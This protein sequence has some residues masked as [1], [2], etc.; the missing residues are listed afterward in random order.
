MM[1]PVRLLLDGFGCYREPAEADFSDVEFFALTGPTGAG[2]STVIDGLCF[3]LYG[4]V[5]RWGNVNVINQALAPTQTECRVALV[6]EAAGQRYGIERRL[7]R[8]PRGQ[9]TTRL[10]MIHRLDPSVPAGAPLADLLAASAEALAEG[11][12]Q[13][14]SHVQQILGLTYE[15]FTQSVLLPQGR[16]AEF[17]QA[18]PRKRQDLLVELLAFGVYEQVAK[19]AR[20]RADLAADRRKTAES[21][22]AELAGATQEAE[23]AAHVRLIELDELGITVTDRLASLDLLRAQGERAAQQASDARQETAMLAAVQ[24]PADVPDLAGRIASAVGALA[25]RKARAESAGLAEMAAHQTR[26]GLGDKAALQLALAAYGHRSDLSERLGLAERDLAAKQADERVKAAQLLAADEAFQQA[27]E[28]LAGTE[29]SNMAAALA[30]GLHVGDDC[31]VCLRALTEPPRHAGVASLTEARS[32]LDQADGQLGLARASHQQAVTAAAAAGSTVNDTRAQLSKLEVSLA[33]GP[34]EAVIADSMAAIETADQALAQARQVAVAA[35]GQVS[36]AEQQRTALAEEEQRAWAALG[37]ARDSVVPF[38]APQLAGLSL[39]ADWVSLAGWA[40]AQG[41]ERRRRQPELD[42][43]AASVRRQV[44]DTEAALFGILSAH[45][46][47]GVTSASAAATAVARHA[48]R[49]ANALIK[50]R[51]DRAKAARL[52]EEIGQR[53]EAEQVASTLGRLL[54]ADEFERWIC[55]EAL[56]SLVAEASQVL[57]R[58]SGG[59]YELV[60]DERNA[61]FVVDHFD[62]DAK[63]PVHTLSGGETF[64]ASLALALALS[65]QVVGLSAGMREMNSMFLDE[66]FG[67]LDSDTLD[68]VGST[69]EGLAAD[70]DRMIG[71]IT[72]VSDLA[73]R[74]G[75]RFVVSRTATTSTLRK[76]SP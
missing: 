1:R 33:E 47:D 5:P 38:G 42:T 40:S 73:E 15:H 27:G 52:D 16:F 30:H 75:T 28:R 23:D 43:A 17:L 21:A 18:E 62:V 22:R 57:I 53:K 24:V 2:K 8:T 19:L 44:D 55:G 67:T 61:L 65:S 20:Q 56:D 9:V 68:T 32:A 3:A 6:F 11:P 60:R 59:Q 39:A 41:A 76:E 70:S 4:T 29:R 45:G 14:R 66:G 48:E 34:P 31:P 74:A 26:E 49:A 58:L 25:E 7:V 13:V 10:A 12:D 64:Q 36:A 54:R 71:I 63:R 37:R 46:I 69:L 50:I 51:D 35:R 72:H